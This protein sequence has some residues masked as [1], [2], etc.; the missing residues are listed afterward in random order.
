LWLVAGK[1]WQTMIHDDIIFAY[2]NHPTM[3]PAKPWHKKLFIF[4]Q[5]KQWQTI[6]YVFFMILTHSLS[7]TSTLLAT[8]K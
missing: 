6:M 8:T 5:H 1:K 4:D 3:V 2:L 7:T